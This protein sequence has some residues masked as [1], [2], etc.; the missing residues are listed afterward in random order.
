MCMPRL[1]ATPED[2]KFGR[3]LA[4]QLQQKRGD[5]GK[6]R[7]AIARVAGISAANLRRLETE[8][9]P[10]VAFVTVGRLARALDLDLEMLFNSSMNG[11]EQ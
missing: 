11:V 1:S 8:G 9:S 7:E 2:R 10:A 3:H 4:D 5:L 6:S